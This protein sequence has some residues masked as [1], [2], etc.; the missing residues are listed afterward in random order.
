MDER[1]A[2]VLDADATLS[3]RYWRRDGTEVWLFVAY[4]AEQQVNSQ[5]H[6]P[7][8]CLPGAGWNVASLEQETLDLGG[9]PQP[10]SRLRMRRQQVQQDVV[11]WFRTQGGTVSGEY[12]LKWDLVKNSLAGR[13]TNAAFIRYSALSADSVALHEVMTL[14]DAPL[15][16]VLGE[17]GL[18]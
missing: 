4:F 5:I 14:L 10:A 2:G 17:V 9:R 12:A 15:S 1:T 16:Q 6:S 13:P 3:R 7:R 8:N 18:R 11:Y